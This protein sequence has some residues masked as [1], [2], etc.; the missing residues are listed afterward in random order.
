MDYIEAAKI[1]K[2]KY[3]EKNFFIAGPINQSVIGQSKFDKGTLALIK[4]NENYIEYLGF[5]KD[6]KIFSQKWIV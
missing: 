2:I 5:I 3:P 6:Y 4:K 1:I